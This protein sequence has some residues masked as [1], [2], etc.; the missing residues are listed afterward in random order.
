MD[1]RNITTTPLKI[2]TVT[3]LMGPYVDGPPGRSLHIYL[4]IRQV[5]NLNSIHA[6]RLIFVSG[7]VE[8][9][10]IFYCSGELK[11]CIFTVTFISLSQQLKSEPKHLQTIRLIIC[12]IER[13]MSLIWFSWTTLRPMFATFIGSSKNRICDMEHKRNHFQWLNRQI[14][15]V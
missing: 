5:L 4:P 15:L 12:N 9:D 2:N 7:N 1:W 6:L 3:C 13:I 14:N 8:S 10:N 11:I